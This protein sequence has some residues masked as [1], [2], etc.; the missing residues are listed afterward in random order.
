MPTAAA[1]KKSRKKAPTPTDVHVPAPTGDPNELL[2]DDQVAKLIGVST[3]TLSI[4]RCKGR[5]NLPFVKIGRLVR[6][7][8]RDVDVWLE[9]RTRHLT[10]ES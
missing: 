7:R 5:Y 2:T 8:R 4:W 3:Q 10:S 1:R 9:L 6:Y